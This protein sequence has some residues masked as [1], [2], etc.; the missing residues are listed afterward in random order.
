MQSQAKPFTLFHLSDFS[1]PREIC[2]LK[3]VD[4]NESQIEHSQNSMT[5]NLQLREMTAEYL[6]KH[7]TL[8]LN[9]LAQRSGVAATTLRRL[10]Q[11]EKRCELA[12]HSV[13]SLVSYLLKEKKISKILKIVQG[14]VAELLNKCFDQ[15]IFDEKTS[16][17]EMRNDL[18]TIFQDKI[19]Y[20]IYKLAANKSGTSIEEVK[21]AFGLMGLKKL[22]D[23]IEKD[24]IHAEGTRLH[25]KQK[26]F[27][28]DLALAHEL[29]HAL[30]DLYKPCDVNHGK[31][32]FYSLSEGMSEEGIN[33]IKEIEKD[34]VKKIYN[35]MN[36]E[37]MQGKIPYFTLV[38]S[39][40]MGPTP[41][42]E[43]QNGAL[44]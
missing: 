41:L 3:L 40:V 27:S 36:D 42:P 20:L 35:L 34:A 37:K 25:G 18:N 30:V 44:Q 28:V 26:N 15:F 1:S 21:D 39:D 29:S 10:M 32:L 19:S 24:L 43:N 11:E 4:M 8:T 22:N 5:L 17:H 16:D 31:N 14:P 6:Q 23:L 7:S 2:L 33:K 13:L 12:P 38:I 9:S